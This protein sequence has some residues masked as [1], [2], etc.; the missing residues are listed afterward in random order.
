MR[1]NTAPAGRRRR[2]EKIPN[3]ICALHLM[4]SGFIEAFL[5]HMLVVPDGTSFKTA[6]QYGGFERHEHCCLKGN[7]GS[8]VFKGNNSYAE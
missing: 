4:S 6:L 8:G 5:V 3:S 7:V 2:Q 1:Y